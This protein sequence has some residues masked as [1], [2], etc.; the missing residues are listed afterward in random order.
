MGRRKKARVRLRGKQINVFCN[1]CGD[2]IIDALPKQ[3]LHPECRGKLQAEAEARRMNYI[4][5]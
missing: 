5:E 2:R 4:P 1:Y 3:R